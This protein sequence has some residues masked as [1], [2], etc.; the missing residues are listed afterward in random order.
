PPVADTYQPVPVPAAL[1]D[2]PTKF[3]FDLPIFYAFSDRP[4][5]NV[6]VFLSDPQKNSEDLMAD[7][8]SLIQESAADEA[9]YL[10]RFKPGKP[11]VVSYIY[12]DL[13]L[14]LRPP[15]KYRSGYN[16]SVQEVDGGGRVV[17]LTPNRSSHAFASAVGP[18]DTVNAVP[19][20]S[21]GMTPMYAAF[22]V[23]D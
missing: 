23:A 20:Q 7:G 3:Q 9:A 15:E 12:D 19:V 13:P 5:Q 6:S 8:A 21:W 2:D 16:F 4:A 1:V 22:D 14:S 10:S 11:I 18:A 17:L